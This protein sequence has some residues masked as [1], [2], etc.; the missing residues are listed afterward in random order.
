[1]AAEASMAIADDASRQSP[2]SEDH[3]QSSETPLGL[4]PARSSHSGAAADEPRPEG[5]DRASSDR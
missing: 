2:I 1:M 4:G 3:Q 5:R